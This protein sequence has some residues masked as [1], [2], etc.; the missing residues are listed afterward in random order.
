MT[1]K[2]PSEIARE[3]LK[4]L[5]ELGLSPTP[6]NYTQCYH[7]ISGAHSAPEMNWHDLM[8]RFC[9]EWERSQSGLSHLQKILSKNQLLEEKNASTLAIK[10]DQLLQKWEKL[11]TRQVQIEPEDINENDS[12]DV[13]CGIWQKLFRTVIR[14]SI[15][16]HD[17]SSTLLLEQ[18]DG[19]LNENE[20]KPDA[21]FPL[22]RD[23]LHHQQELE[24]KEIKIRKGLQEL[25]QLLLRNVADLLDNDAFLSGQMDVVRQ[26]VQIADNH[27][28]LDLAIS[29]VKEVIFQQG[30]LKS[31]VR[32]AREAIRDLVNLVLI[33]VE[34]MA[35]ENGRNHQQLE[36]LASELDSA[37]DW[38]QI[39]KIVSAVLNT[40]KNISKQSI[41]ARNTL[42]QAKN[43]LNA[44]QEKIRK[45]EEEMESISQL[46]HVDPLTGTLNRRGLSAAFA[47]ESAR[48]Q[49]LNQP[50]TV[51]IVDLDHFKQ[52]ND[53]H[54]HDLGDQVLQGMAKILQ[55]TLRAND[56]ITRYGGEEFVILMP[57][58]MPENALDILE[59][60]QTR[61]GRQ[62]FQTQDQPLKISFSGG[63][64][65]WQNSCSQE[66]S[67][68]AAD[69]AMYHAKTD[70]RQRIYLA[71]QANSSS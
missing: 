3:A 70:G 59:R 26:A 9:T 62:L 55:D 43:R 52:V 15:R 2:T 6:E 22:A 64:S 25:L 48:A 29:R 21:L 4:R 35:G 66:Q 57:D 46:V 54:G 23:L 49:R 28:E 45:L 14:H 16:D 33:S 39:R 63:I 65:L 47:R 30:K 32:E 17:Q 61:L 34:S 24:A 37:T 71:D 18:L 68:A 8:R 67:I 31:E 5:M 40:S 41:E 50:L 60:V 44:A 11:S 13:N 27:E 38:Q 42:L 53:Q 19:L 10:L 69:K 56:V 20:I 36:S 51:A 12:D 1:N 58:T 7:E